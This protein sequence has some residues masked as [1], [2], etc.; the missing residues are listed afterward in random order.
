[1]R[2][3]TIFLMGILLSAAVA[4]LSAAPNPA[5]TAAK[6]TP[7][8][9]L[10]EK[11]GYTLTLVTQDI[12]FDGA[13]QQR[14][15]DVFFEVYPKLAKNFNKKA[16]KEVTITIDTAYDGVAYAHDGKVTIA[17]AW[18]VKNPGDVDV[19]TH[20]VM[21]LVQAYPPRSGPGWLVEG[22]ADYVRHRYGVAN[23]DANWALPELKPEHHYTNSYRITARFLDWVERT[24]KKGTVK[25]LDYA[26]R[27]Q[28]YAEDLWKTLTGNSLDELW[29]AYAAAQTEIMTN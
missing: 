2:Y 12:T 20:E 5:R 18:L 25:K 28:H 9:K 26:L 15:A 19:V 4:G 23:P 22:I 21:H 10:L 17:Q 3:K 13:L 27:N 8:V 29:S 16:V 6:E 1:M 14:L 24:K 11:K 7:N